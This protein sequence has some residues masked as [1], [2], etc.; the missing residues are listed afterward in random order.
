[1]DVSISTWSIEDPCYALVSN[2]YV[3]PACIII[4][5]FRRG[6]PTTR[7]NICML[8]CQVDDHSDVIDLHRST[9]LQC[10]STGVTKDMFGADTI[11]MNQNKPSVAWAQLVCGQYAN[12]DVWHTISVFW[13]GGRLHSGG[14]FPRKPDMHTHTN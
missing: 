2:C 1:M 10:I 5:R 7:N 13:H 14:G 3:P 6:M 8:K 12:S 9:T 11:T 4:L